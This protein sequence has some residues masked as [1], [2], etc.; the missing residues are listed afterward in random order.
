MK[1]LVIGFAGDKGVGKTTAC[2]VFKKAGF[3]PVSIEAKIE[4]FAHYLFPREEI[5]KNKD[6]ILANV[7]RSGYK[8]ARSYWLNLVLTSIP[9][10]KN[11]I[12]IDDV[13]EN[14]ALNNAIQTYQICRSSSS[15]SSFIPN[16]EIILNDVSKDEFVTKLLKLV[17]NFK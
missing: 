4:E 16:A 13:G 10:D 12:V 2:N 15:P 8:A 14:E 5:E 1:R 17:K 6:A 9:D 3:Y 11:L 7:R